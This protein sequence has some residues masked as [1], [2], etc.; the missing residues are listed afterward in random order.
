MH[1]T[2]QVRFM[3]SASV[4]FAAVGSLAIIAGGLVAAATAHAPTE[5][6]TWAAAYLVLV[7]GVCQLAISAALALLVPDLP[8]RGVATA[9]LVMFNAANAGVVVGTTTS[10]NWLLAAGSV[11]LLAALAALAFSVR[12]ANRGWPLH[13]YYAVIVVLA[14][15]VP[16]GLILQH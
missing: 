8:I 9:A 3:D 1:T 11:L 15:S 6:G 14:V 16:I 12:G 7:V 10:W 4:P 13:A 2:E 5:H